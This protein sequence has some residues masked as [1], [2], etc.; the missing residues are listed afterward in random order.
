MKIVK[1]FKCNICGRIECIVDNEEKDLMCCGEEMTELKPNTVDAAVEKHIPTYSIEGDM[2]SVKVG[3][4]EHP[5]TEEHYIMWIAC[6]D[7]NSVEFVKLTP[8]DKPEARFKN[9][10]QF[11]LYAYCNLHGLWKNK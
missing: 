7:N 8:N 9:A 10:E 5:M 6:F 11:E 3:D 1:F 2:I 4:I